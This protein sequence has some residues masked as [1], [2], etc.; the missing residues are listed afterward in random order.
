MCKAY[1][2]NQPRQN[3]WY[4]YVWLCTGCHGAW[5][6]LSASTTA[7]DPWR[8]LLTANLPKRRDTTLSHWQY[9]C[10]VH[11]S[12]KPSEA[13]WNTLKRFETSTCPL[14]ILSDTFAL[15]SNKLKVVG[16]ASLN[17]SS[18]LAVRGCQD[19]VFKSIDPTKGA[20]QADVFQEP[21]QSICDRS[22]AERGW[23]RLG[24]RNS[25]FPKKTQRR[26]RWGARN[27]NLGKCLGRVLVAKTW[28]SNRD[29]KYG[30]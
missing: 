25:N 4:A 18:I 28:S 11:S 17:V 30:K 24:G 5:N 2:L 12:V 13:F 14:I 6:S 19:S 10:C 9:F 22:K 16:L 1:G 3:E 23:I 15:T 7:S 20:S 21:N 8:S 27:S 26:N 29:W